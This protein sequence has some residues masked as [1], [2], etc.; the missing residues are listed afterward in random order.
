MIRTAT[1]EDAAAIATIQAHGWRHAYADIVAPEDMHEASEME[2]RWRERLVDPDIG[3]RVFAQDG[4]VAGFATFGASREDDAAA[5]T[6]ELYALYVEPAA[7]GA[8]V[9]SALLQDAVGALVELTFVDATLRTFEAN[10]LARAFYERHGWV[11]DP[12]VEAGDPPTVRY[13][14]AL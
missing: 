11:L 1:V 8:G 4:V 6:G 7:Q 2:P 10:G 9:G 13:R 3:A 5:R 12:P 14:R